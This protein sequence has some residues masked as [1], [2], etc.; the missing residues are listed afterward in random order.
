M[1][2]L[3]II[4]C[5]L[6]TDVLFGSPSPSL[7]A[8][9]PPYV[10][11]AIKDT[12]L[13]KNFGIVFITNLQDHFSDTDIGYVLT[14]TASNL[15]IG[16][17]SLISQD[18]LYLQSAPDF[19]GE[20]LIR[21]RAFDGMDSVAD[22]FK[23]TIRETAPSVV[24]AIRDT[25]F[26][27]DA[28]TK[29]LVNNLY[30]VFQDADSPELT[31]TTFVIGGGITSEIIND[32]LRISTA[33]DSF[34][35]YRVVVKATDELL[36]SVSDTFTVTITPVNDAPRIIFHIPD[37]SINE[38]IGK[39]FIAKMTNVFRDP[40]G[41]A[42]TYTTSTSNS[43]KLNSMISGDSL[44]VLTVKDSNGVVSVYI[45]ATDPSAL[46]ARD[47]FLLTVTPFNDPPHI[48][49]PLRDT[50]FVQDFGRLFI[51]KLTDHFSD[52]DGDAV[53]FSPY[54][55]S[56]GVFPEVSNDSLY[57]RS[58]L[59]FFGNV[60]VVIEAFDDF[61]SITDTFAVH[62]TNV[63]DPPIVLHWFN[64]VEIDEDAGDVFL[65][66]ISLNFVEVDNDP[67][68][69]AAASSDS[70]RLIGRISNDSLYVTPVPDS[71]GVVKLYLR[72]VD[73]FFEEALDSI[74]ITIR[75]I[76]DPPRVVNAVRDTV[77]L[78]NFG[79]VFICKLT[80]VFSDV[81]S[82]VLS[83]RV[84]SLSPG[85][86]KQISNDSLYLHSIAGFAGIV[87]F[88]VTASDGSLSTSDTFKVI[89]LDQSKPQI[90]V[91]AL[92]SP[93][94]NI[95]RFAA[96]ANENLNA[97]TLTA[98][99]IAVVMSKQGN[100][101]FGDYALT[102]T[103]NLAVTVSATDLSGNQDTVNRLYQVSR[104][105][106]PTVFGKY[107]FAGSGEGYLLL[108]N[109]ENA[110]V[111]L[112]WKRLGENLDLIMTET[113]D[114]LNVEVTYERTLLTDDETKIG[115]YEY[116]NGQWFYRGGEGQKGKVTTQLQKSGTY[117]VL[118]NPDHIVLPRNFVLDQN[119]PNPFNPSTTIR[120]E[121]PAESRVTIKIYNLLGQEIK[122]LVNATKG[123]GR[124]EVIWDGKNDSGR[125]VA[126]GLYL[127]RLETGKISKTRKMLFVK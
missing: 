85:I 96:G 112:S 84:D 43:S 100:T 125:E 25:S 104:L 119:Y 109:E 33:P 97:L 118:F 59:Y 20:V 16:V 47:T 86:A 73:P 106:K 3:L 63:N 72:A 46:T 110:Q 54:R 19:V 8:N 26:L 95:V 76:N 52:I 10:N 7:P 49:K 34:G 79:K 41:D 66:D 107:L 29:T 44:Y 83:Y 6:Q 23:V 101:Y 57:L 99:N 51:T 31:F 21:I 1:K 122:T 75:S 14:Y 81:D 71:S 78:Q 87:N 64:D 115:L 111:P 27:E 9:N 68:T 39:K 35:V 5:L 61:E 70:S 60:E 56:Y 116:V 69:Y 12:V 117:A 102:A 67:L 32:G 103:G 94:L 42:L 38:D 124:Y 89:V 108:S 98:N 65:G 90:F 62:V 88:K 45:S 77:L 40:D 48:V 121:V 92:A 80:S 126:S 120:Y 13:N 24:N 123:I 93:V 15:S 18:S 11:D 127:Y 50:A 17:T 105:N 30:T 37:G 22:T 4:F 28:G 74:R 2:F 82:L 55:L 58:E 53:Y 91:N 113:N 36:Q 114:R